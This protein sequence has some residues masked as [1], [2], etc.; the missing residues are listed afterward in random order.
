MTEREPDYDALTYEELVALLESLTQQ[1][2]SGA[3]GIEEAAEL[4]E[5]AGRVH[6]LAAERLE[7]VRARIDE[8]GGPGGATGGAG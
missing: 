4:Y 1:M 6:A 7:K 8:L 5:R 3:I 2:A